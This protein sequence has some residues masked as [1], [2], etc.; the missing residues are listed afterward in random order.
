MNGEQQMINALRNL[1]RDRRGNA[2]LLAAGAFPLVI[3]SVG[4]ATDTIQWAMWKR[5]LQRAADSAAISGV[6]AQVQGQAVTSAVNTDLDKNNRTGVTLSSGYP[7]ITFPSSNPAWNTATRV[8]LAMQ[9]TLSFSS[10]FMSAAPIISATATAAIVPTG[11]YC[12][13]AMINTSTTGIFM[14]GNATVNLKCGMMTNSTSLNA[15]VATGSSNVI[16]SPIAAVGGIQASNNYA[17]GTQ[18]LPF[19]VATTDPFAAVPDR[20]PAGSSCANDPKPTPSETVTLSAGCYKGLT[21]K[22]NVTLSPGV[23][24]ID[25]GDLQINSGA[26]VSGTGVTVVL[27]NSSSNANAPIGNVTLNGGA[28]ISLSAPSSGVYKGLIMMQ[29]RRATD[30]G[31]S[32]APNKINGNSMSFYQGAFYFPK[33]LLDFGGNSGINTKCVQIVAWRLTF[34]G[35][36]DITNVCPPTSGAS[37]FTGQAVRLVG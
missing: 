30:G 18:L 8:D 14:T 26:T 23:Y 20:M 13:K 29:D 16:A 36:S 12:A 28:T 27:T 32:S 2:V 11:E 5:Q 7:V 9:K 25:A 22:G 21:L 4:L 34:S 6:Y 35:N 3:G 19:S 1:W 37:A 33:Q 15:A 31:G 10:V 17:A 24:Y